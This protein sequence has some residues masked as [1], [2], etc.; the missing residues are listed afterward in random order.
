[1][2]PFAIQFF[3]NAGLFA[4]VL[5]IPNLARDQLGANSIEI[6]LIV[7]SYSLALFVS[8]YIFGRASDVHGRRMVLRIGLILSAISLTLQM[9]AIDT[10]TLTIARLMVGFCAGIFPSALMAYAFDAE[11][12]TRF[13]VFGFQGFGSGVLMVIGKPLLAGIVFLW[14]DKRAAQRFGKGYMSGE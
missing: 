11:G 2:K 13:M 14:G 12:K 1:M 9:L 5:L 10:F 8:S 7:A 6:G 3:S 4:S